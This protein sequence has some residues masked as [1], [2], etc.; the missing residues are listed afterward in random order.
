LQVEDV[1]S[2]I[3]LREEGLSDFELDNPSAQAC[4][5]QEDGRIKLYCA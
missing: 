2:R 5:R 4:A 3:T 1:L